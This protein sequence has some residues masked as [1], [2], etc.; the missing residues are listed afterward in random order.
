MDGC[1]QDSFYHCVKEH[2]TGD[3]FDMKRIEEVLD[4]KRQGFPEGVI[5]VINYSTNHD[6]HHLIAEL[7]ER[8]IFGAEAF[9]RVKLGAVLLMTVVGVPLIWMGEE[10]GQN[11]HKTTEEPSFLE[12]S[13]LKNDL[14]RDLFEYYKA[15]IALRTQTSALQ[16]G[17]IEF[18][19]E[20]PKHKVFAYVRSD[21]RGS[22]VVVVANFSN[23]YL[24]GYR[25]PDFP[26]NGTWH[27]WTKD[28]D[29]QSDDNQLTVDLAEYEAQVFV[30]Q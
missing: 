21:D 25:I 14:N 10:F 30:W 24:A 7:G 13:L 2:I 15:L 1:W 4:A 23:Q 12:W 26:T 17:N 6:H 11:K 28:Y 22:Q 3:T 20:N 29:I 18:F 8:G 27:E 19:Y 9:K 5:K 16:A